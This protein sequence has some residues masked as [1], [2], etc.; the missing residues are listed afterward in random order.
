MTEKL[1]PAA[2]DRGAR[3]VRFLG[4]NSVA[5]NSE[6]FAPRQVEQARAIAMPEADDAQGDA[7]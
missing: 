2:R 5:T 6:K 1:N 4:K 3:Q 7:S